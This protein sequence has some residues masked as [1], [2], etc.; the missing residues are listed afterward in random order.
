M[1]AH[2]YFADNAEALDW[3]IDQG[4]DVSRTDHECDDRGKKLAGRGTGA[5]NRDYSLKVLNNI[6]ARGD[7][8]LFDHIVSRGAE[9]LR[10]L[11]LHR[12]SN[13]KD[14]ETNTR[15]IDHLLDKHHMNV[16]AHT[17]ELRD[18][19][20]F[21][22]DSGTP[23]VCGGYYENLAAVQHLLKRGA[24]TNSALVLAISKAMNGDKTMSMVVHT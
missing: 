24:A 8:E 12:A 15:M 18:Y 7:T 1:T 14:A 20:H 19:A 23:F 9:P 5:R 22:G 17:S 4:V 13:I 2:S 16:E 6:A 10:S 3:L 11:A 21:P